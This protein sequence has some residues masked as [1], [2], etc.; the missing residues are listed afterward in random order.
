MLNKGKLFDDFILLICNEEMSS[1]S[2]LAES[3]PVSSM[4]KGI[5]WV[6]SIERRDFLTK[7]EMDFLII[8]LLNHCG[9]HSALTLSRKGSKSVPRIVQHLGALLGL[10]ENHA[11]RELSLMGVIS[12]LKLVQS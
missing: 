6:S 4:S 1:L 7:I 10:L 3:T 8:I 11:I 5:H 12:M 2:L 9:W